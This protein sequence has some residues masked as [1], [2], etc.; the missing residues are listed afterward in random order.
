MTA[1]TLTA[2]QRRALLWLA[3]TPGEWRD[4]T[5]CPRATFQSFRA[6]FRRGLVER[7]VFYCRLTPSGIKT[8]KELGI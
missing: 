8:V 6:L 3:E 1:R 2:P 5:K 7:S 4:A